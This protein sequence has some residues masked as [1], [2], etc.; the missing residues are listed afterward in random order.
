MNR[1]LAVYV[2][3]LLRKPAGSIEHTI[4]QRVWELHDDVDLLNYLDDLMEANA[5]NSRAFE[6]ASDVWALTWRAAA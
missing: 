6:I 2:A 4:G 3:A 1:D 5:E